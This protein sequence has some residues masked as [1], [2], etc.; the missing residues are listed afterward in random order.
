[1]PAMSWSS[2]RGRSVGGRSGSRG[3]GGPS[4]SARDGAGDHGRR[5]RCGRCRSAGTRASARL[6]MR[7]LSSSVRARVGPLEVLE[8]EHDRRTLGQVGQ[9]GQDRLEQPRLGHA[10]GDAARAGVGVDRA[11]AGITAP[12]PGGQWPEHLIGFG[13]P[14]SSD[15]LA[16]D[17]DDGPVGQAATLDG[18]AAAGGDER[19]LF[20]GP[21]RRTRRGVSSC[22]HRPRRRPGRPRNGPS[23][24]DVEARGQL[25]E[26]GSRDRRSSG[27]RHPLAHAA[28]VARRTGEIQSAAGRGRRTAP[29]TATSS[30]L[31]VSHLTAPG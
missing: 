19:S 4:R 11:S 9:R 14:K 1:M 26:L 21:G 29:P 27:H 23:T 7:K 6:R 18:D 2:R 24:A 20:A 31:R 30:E 12:R 3:R 28:S 17:A 13:W 10:L 15:D 22:R 5:P 25:I 8:H 16:H